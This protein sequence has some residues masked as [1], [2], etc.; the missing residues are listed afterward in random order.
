MFIKVVQHPCR[1]L[2]VSVSTDMCQAEFTRAADLYGDTDIDPL[3]LYLP[4]TCTHTH[5]HPHTHSCTHIHAVYLR[6]RTI[7]DCV[8][9]FH[10]SVD[11]FQQ[12]FGPV[13]RRFNS[14]LQCGHTV[15]I[16]YTHTGTHTYTP[17]W[18]WWWRLPTNKNSFLILLIGKS[19]W[20]SGRSR[21]RVTQIR[22]K[23]L[24]LIKLLFKLYP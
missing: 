7:G 5:T 11:S 4:L 15:F 6:S 3:Y 1:A 13:S 2:C 19:D 20:Q 24:R 16:L 21:W 22:N 23:L 17:W 8:E 10:G 14:A 18:W 12:V 9:S